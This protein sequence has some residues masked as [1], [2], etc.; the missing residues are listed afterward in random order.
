M[1]PHQLYSLGVLWTSL[2]C[3]AIPASAELAAELSVCAAIA[4]DRQ[5]LDCYDAVSG[6]LQE[7]AE[8]P[9]DASREAPAAPVTSLSMEQELEELP[10]FSGMGRTAKKRGRWLGIQPYR[11]NYILPVTY[12]ERVNRTLLDDTG[13]S[14]RAENVLG[15][16]L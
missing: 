8:K 10:T 6:R 3:T 2:V 14:F 1:K 5:R 11:R 4:E 15:S 13:E 12:N 7:A 16:I 9:G